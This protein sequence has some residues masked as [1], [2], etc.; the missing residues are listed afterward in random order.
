MTRACA[1][2]RFWH[3]D[4]PVHTWAAPCDL[5]IIAKPEAW[6]SCSHFTDRERAKA[7][8]VMQSETRGP[9]QMWGHRKP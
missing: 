3:T 1:D 5:G 4:D 9:Y 7:E 6:Q 8:K 2:C